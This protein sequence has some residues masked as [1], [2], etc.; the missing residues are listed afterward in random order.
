MDWQNFQWITSLV[1][2]PLIW[3]VW[4]NSRAIDK[5]LW[6][7]LHKHEDLDN[8]FHLDIIQNV[9][10]NAVRDLRAYM[11]SRFDRLEDKIEKGK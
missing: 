3:K 11:D 1:I 9:I 8:K 7:A 10:P 4:D 2:L 6:D 5:D